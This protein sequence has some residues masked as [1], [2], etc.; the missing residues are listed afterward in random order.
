MIKKLLILGVIF[1]NGCAV[2]NDRTPPIEVTVIPNDCNN[3][4]AILRWLNSQANQEQ[5]LLTNDRVYAQHQKAIKRKIW[6]IKYNCT[7]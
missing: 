4:D 6:D 7:D 2:Y 1:L 3:R 5:A